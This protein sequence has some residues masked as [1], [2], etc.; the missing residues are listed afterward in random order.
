L[1][2]TGHFYFAGIRTFLLCLDRLSVGREGCVKVGRKA[3]LVVWVVSHF[4]WGADPARG[5]Q[6]RVPRLRDRRYMSNQ[7][8]AVV[9]CLRSLGVWSFG[10]DTRL[11]GVYW[12][13][14]GIKSRLKTQ[15]ALAKCIKALPTHNR[16]AATETEQALV[17]VT[18]DYSESRPITLRR[19]EGHGECGQVTLAD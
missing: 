13:P 17:R 10:S 16:A 11:R 2:R 12:Q 14:A 1:L 9:R 3:A 19:L 15:V 8:S 6:V 7:D 18:A 5:R 4:E